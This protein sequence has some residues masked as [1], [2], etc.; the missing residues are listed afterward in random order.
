MPR[1]QSLERRLFKWMLALALTPALIALLAGMWV[2]AGS[3]DWMGTLGP[4]DRVA[5][6]GRVVFEAAEAAAAEDSALADALALHREELS[7]SLSL[8]RRWAYLGDR[9]V[10][11][12][13]FIAIALA[14]SLAGLALLASRRVAHQVA[15]PIQDLVEWADHLGRDEPLPAP[16]P[17]ERREVD[18]VRVLRTAL[19]R[20]SRDLVQ[21]RDR[22]IEAERLRI[23]GEM[24]RRIAHEMKNPLTP[25]R[26]ATHRMVRD[27]GA[28]ELDEPVAV[29]LEE[30]DRLEELARQFAALGQ[31]PD[32]PT[33]PVDLLELISELLRSDVPPAVETS[34]EAAGTLPL[35][36]GHY[37]ALVRAFRNLISNAVEAMEGMGPP[38]RID[39]RLRVTNQGTDASWIE[40]DVAD[41]GCGIPAEEVERVFEPDFSTK[42]RGTGLG[43]AL[44]RQAIRAHGGEVSA[45]EREGGG[46][47]FTTRLPAETNAVAA[48]I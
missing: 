36:D 34:L 37:E 27:G 33:S 44:V 15:R 1:R 19:R 29:I 48:R 17:G 13:P 7:S 43:L 5:E 4:W 8:A 16:R 10:A 14:L 3:F 47:V 2:W 31:P 24:A 42:S 32:G 39:V 18:E 45:R 38:R 20:A 6:S 11:L 9:F 46:T 26:L 41:R 40:I 23:W 25:L 35:V 30:T 28:S 22:T 12:L 21:A